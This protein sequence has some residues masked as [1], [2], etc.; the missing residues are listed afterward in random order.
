MIGAAVKTSF[1]VEN[2]R[3]I[4]ISWFL[5]GIDKIPMQNE[6]KNALEGHMDLD[7]KLFCWVN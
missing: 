4:K 2:V 7:H 6:Y 1:Y 3:D 5:V